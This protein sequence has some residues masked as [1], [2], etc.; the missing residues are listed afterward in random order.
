MHLNHS[1]FIVIIII[2]MSI[3]IIIISNIKAASALNINIFKV[4]KNW[5]SKII[6]TYLRFTWKRFGNIIGEGI[7]NIVTS[8]HSYEV[9]ACFVLWDKGTNKQTKIP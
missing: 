9:Y 1:V 3:I 4:E 2:I 5:S 6:K 7:R 8:W